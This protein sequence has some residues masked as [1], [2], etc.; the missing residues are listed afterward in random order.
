MHVG[1]CWST[2]TVETAVAE[3][4]KKARK[5]LYCL[6]SAGLHGENGLDPKTSLHLYQ[7]Y[8]LPVLLYGIKVVYPRPKIME[9]QEQV[10]K[11]NIKHLLSFLVTVAD[12]AVNILSTTFPIKVMIHQ[13]VLTFFDNFSLLSDTSIEKRLAARQ[14]AVKSFDI[15]CLWG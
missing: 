5:T 12:P 1:I 9:V 13:R 15:R 8:V 2:D 4:V 6:M 7:I 10:Y 11:H 14:L 3:N